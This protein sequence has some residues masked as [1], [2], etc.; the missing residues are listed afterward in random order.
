M[1]ADTP[2]TNLNRTG[3]FTCGTRFV[4]NANGRITHV[5][6]WFGSGGNTRRLSVWSA[7]GVKLAGVVDTVPSLLEVLGGADPARSRG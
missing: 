4:V 5:R 1:L 3:G 7:A 2:P 6:Y